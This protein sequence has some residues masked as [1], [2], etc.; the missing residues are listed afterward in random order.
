MGP[1]AVAAVTAV[2]AQPDRKVRRKCTGS[3]GN[4]CAWEMLQKCFRNASDP[5]HPFRKADRVVEGSLPHPS[6]LSRALK[7]MQ[8]Y[9]HI[10]STVTSYH[11]IRFNS[12]QRPV[13]AGCGCCRLP[14]LR[15]AQRHR[16]RIQTDQRLQPKCW[17]RWASGDS[18]GSNEHKTDSCCWLLQNVSCKNW[19]EEMIRNDFPRNEWVWRCL[20]T[21]RFAE[22]RMKPQERKAKPSMVQWHS[23][24]NNNKSID[25][26]RNQAIHLSVFYL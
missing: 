21:Q 14:A 9:N 16:R 19:K 6:R 11:I 23:R 26:G 15:S 7:N 5:C 22:K 25:A 3:A 1:S 18:S 20:P 10:G 4:G 8:H 24:W 12:R 17:F 2:T 13:M